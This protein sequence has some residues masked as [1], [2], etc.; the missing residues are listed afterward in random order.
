MGVAGIV[1]QPRSTI[2]V[3][4]AVTRWLG[5]TSSCF[6]VL[7]VTE[8]SIFFF[9]KKNLELPNFLMF[10]PGIN[11]ILFIFKYFVL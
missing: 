7:I 1:N 4:G 2:M 11:I 6:P 5:L 9:L 8:V 10:V 3:V